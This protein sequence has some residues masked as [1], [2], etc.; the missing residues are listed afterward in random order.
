MAGFEQHAQ[1]LAPQVQR[2]H[3][4]EVLDAAVVGQLLVLAVA[5]AEGFAHQVVQVRRLFRREQGPLAVFH[6]PLHE[7]VRHPVGGVHVVGAAAVVAGVLAQFEEFLDVAVP[8]F[9]VAAHRALALAALVHRHRG[10]VG[11]LEEGDHAVALAVG[12]LDVAAHAAHRR[13]VVAQAA[14]KLGQHGVVVDG[15]E[16]AVQVVRDLRQITGR[17]LRPQR[18]GVEQRRRAAH[19]VERGQQGVE[20]DGPPFAVDLVHRQAHRHAH[21]EGLRQLDAVLV[22]VDEVA[23]VQGL[24]AQV[25]ELRIALRQQRLAQPVQVVQ[26]QLRVEQLQLRRAVDELA[27]VV[28]VQPLHVLEGRP[29]LAHAQELQRLVAHRVQQQAGRGVGV[30]RLLLDAGARRQGQRLGQLVLGNAVVEVAQRRRHHL[31]R[32]GAAE[33]GAGLAGDPAQALLVERD[34]AAVVQGHADGAALGGAGRGGGLLG[35]RLG[36]ALLG[37]LLAV[38]HVVAG[39]LVL[40]GAHHRQFHLVLDVLDVQRAAAGHMAGQRLHHLLG[41]RLDR[42][43]H[44]RTGRRLAAFNR[45][46]SLGQRDRDFARIERGQLAIAANHFDRARGGGGEFGAGFRGRGAA[47][48]GGCNLSLHNF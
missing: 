3:A 42:G 26:G 16:D 14:G 8:G 21:E 12:A 43:A 13:P 25:V 11:H 20:L 41:Q 23:V 24:Q 40:A 15:V 44:A 32:I 36:G 27:E 2:R 9:Q 35:S 33:I 22:A 18:A 19:E 38:Q 17:K 37:A 5:Q 46:K 1:H 7:Q 29:R 28:A 30:V 4:L 34:G 6:H 47:R 10:V 48:R 31:V 39:H 45:Q